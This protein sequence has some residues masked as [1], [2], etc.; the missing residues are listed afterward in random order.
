MANGRFSLGVLDPAVWLPDWESG[1]LF[2]IPG[3]FLRLAS[4]DVAWVASHGV[5]G[6]RSM[7]VLVG[8]FVLGVFD[9]AVWLPDRE[10]R[11]ILGVFVFDWWGCG[12]ISIS[13]GCGGAWWTGVWARWF[14]LVGAPVASP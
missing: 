8:G 11:S 9:P 14:V 12:S 7:S 3:V 2:G 1:C 10:S 6:F 4:G 13:A 5:S